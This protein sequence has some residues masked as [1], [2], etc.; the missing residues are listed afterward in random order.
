MIEI[1]RAEINDMPKVRELAH[2]IW[3]SAYGSILSAE[4]LDYMLNLIYSISSLEHQYSVLN[5]QFI[6]VI[7]NKIPVAFASFSPH[8]DATV[9]HLN[10]IYV[11]P[12]QQGKSIGKKMLNYIIEEI[13]KAGATTLQLNVNRHNKALNFYK[14]Q[15]FKIIREEDIDIGEGYFMNDYVLELKL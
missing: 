10:K 8:E 11:L 6:L 9:Y 5:H 4:Q 3:P 13:R 7:E 1:K 2:K 14:K 15:G 12:G